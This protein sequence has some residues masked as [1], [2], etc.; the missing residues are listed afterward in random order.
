[1]P[2]H[3]KR[4]RSPEVIHARG[5]VRDFG[6]LR[7]VDQSVVN[8][9]VPPADERLMA[10]L[11]QCFKPEVVALSEYLGRDLVTLWGYDRAS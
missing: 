5:L 9:P 3:V 10:E 6:A 4:V 11:R 7:A 1:M 2:P 8:A